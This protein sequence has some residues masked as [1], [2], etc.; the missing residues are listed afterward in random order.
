MSIGTDSTVPVSLNCSACGLV[1]KTTFTS[2]SIEDGEL[3]FVHGIRVGLS[4]YFS[5]HPVKLALKRAL[6]LWIESLR[7]VLMSPVDSSS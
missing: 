7:F 1:L 3:K 5:P 2:I 4:L 6:R